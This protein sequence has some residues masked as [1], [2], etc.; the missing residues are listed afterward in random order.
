MFKR[1]LVGALIF[2]AVA[3]PPPAEARTCAPRDQIIADLGKKF[4]ET[5]Q[6]AGIQSA[7]QVMELWSS[8][9]TGSWTLLMTTSRG[10]SCIVAAGKSWTPAPK[11]EMAVGD[12]A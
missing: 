5:R 4:G 7:T 9:S 6:A 8:D 2:G 12:P 3:T 11:I 1:L 10:I